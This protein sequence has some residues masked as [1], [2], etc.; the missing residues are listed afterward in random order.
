MHD[1]KTYSTHARAVIA[2]ALPLAGSQLAQF[3]LHMTD[4]IMMGWFGLNEL[5]ALVLASGY[6]FITFILLAG[7]AFAVM[8]LVANAAGAGDTT[9]VRRSTRM[10]MWLSVLAAVAIYPLFGF[11]ERVLIALRQEPEI[12]ALAQPY[13][14]VAG[15]EMLPA[16]IAMVLRSY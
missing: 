9:V 15:I 1:Q 8:P 2:L 11:S 4:V 5:A 14:I 13:L 7:F 10:A 12:A 3:A 16:L 6:W